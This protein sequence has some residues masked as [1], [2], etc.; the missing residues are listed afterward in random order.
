M[1]Q[2]SNV[3]WTIAVLGV[4]GILCIGGYGLYWWIAK[5]STARQYDV[6]TGTQQYQSGLISQERDLVIGYHRTTDD[7]QK[8][9]ISDQFCA[10]YQQLTPPPADLASAYP[11]ICTP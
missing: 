6:N 11:T 3:F 2:A 9:A 1:K 10:I 7:S 4:V 8:A 5:D